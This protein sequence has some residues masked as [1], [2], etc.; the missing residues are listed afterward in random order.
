MALRL[1]TGFSGVTF[2]IAVAVG[3]FLKLIAGFIE[4]G[5]GLGAAFD[6]AGFAATGTVWHLVASDD[7]QQF[8]NE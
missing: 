2:P 5:K 3:D 6:G 7:L 4:Q 8:D 1:G